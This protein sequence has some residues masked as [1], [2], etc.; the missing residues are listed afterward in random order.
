VSV[1]WLRQRERGSPIAWRFMIW[2]ALSVGRPTA[3]VL[4][5]PICVYYLAFSKQASRA[6]QPYLS[7]ALGSPIS[8]RDLYRQYYCFASTLLDRVYLLTG[9]GHHFDID[10][11]GL[12]VL[13]DRVGRGKGCILL[14]SHLGSFEV[15][16]A[17]G[18][19]QQEVEI[20]V[21]MYEQNTPMIRDLFSKLNPAVA[22]SVIQT[23]SPNTMLQVKE[24]LD[25]GGMVGILAD[26]LVNQDQATDCKFFGK[27]ARFPAGTMWLASILKVPVI[28]FFGLYRGDNRYEVHFEL[29]AEEVT[30]DRRY[31]DQEVQQWTQRYADRLEHYCRL[32]AD[33]W[34]NFY[35]FWEEQR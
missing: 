28:L 24:C 15:V 26:R 3:R 10:I 8:R 32:A 34:F 35:D 9:Q 2:I 17:I 18:L 6:I 21:L 31:R 29:F 4:L 14:G 20:K 12:E 23:G 25:R 16:R 1:G 33:N 19:S 5:Y 22:D 30:I 11:R 27:R 13:K 7:R